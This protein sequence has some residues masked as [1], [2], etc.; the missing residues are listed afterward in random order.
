MKIVIF[1]GE[2][3]RFMLHG[4]V[5]VMSERLRSLGLPSLEYR[6]LRHDMEQTYKIVRNI[7]IVDKNQVV[8]D[9]F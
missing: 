4:R 7:D 8:Y 5:L 3:N 6:R 1:T 2:K 9:H